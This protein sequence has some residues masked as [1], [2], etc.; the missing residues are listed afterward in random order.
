MEH[1]YSKVE[2]KGWLQTFLKVLG[3][4]AEVPAAAFNF[5]LKISEFVKTKAQLSRLK[6]QN[7]A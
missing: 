2:K 3:R 7:E 5:T 6:Y 1:Q 4:S